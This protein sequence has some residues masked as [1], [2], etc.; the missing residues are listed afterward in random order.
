MSPESSSEH[1]LTEN[2]TAGGQQPTET[3]NSVEKFDG[4]ILYNP[5]GST[6]IIEDPAELGDNELPKQE[7]S[8]YDDAKEEPREEE[9]RSYPQIAN[10]HVVSRSTAYYNALYGQ[11]VVKLLQERNVPE[12]PVVHSYRVYSARKGS[13]PQAV[14]SQDSEQKPSLPSLV[15]VKPIL[16]CFICKLSFGCAKTFANHCLDVH[17]FSLSDEEQS[18]LDAK[19][20]S[21]ILQYVGKE[22][23]VTL[24][25]LEPFNSSSSTDNQSSSTNPMGPPTPAAAAGP[26][27]NLVSLMQNSS[28]KSGGSSSQPPLSPGAIASFLSVVA[29]AQQANKSSLP[30]V[31]NEDSKEDSAGQDANKSP[32]NNSFTRYSSPSPSSTSAFPAATLNNMT[33]TNANMLQG[34]TIGACPD[35]I[36]G[37]PTC[38]ECTKCDL[39]LSSSRM[40]GGTGWNVSRNSCKTL[41]CPKCNWHYKY[42]ETL[43]IHMKEKHPESETTCIYCITGQQH[44]RLARGETYTCGYKPYRCEVCNYSTTTKGNLSIHMQSDK[45]L[46]NMQELQNG[47]PASLSA[48]SPMASNDKISPGTSGRAGM[49]LPP[50]MSPSS[51][52][53]SPSPKPTWRC[54]VCNY[55]TN[56]ARNLRIHMTS[57]KHT[58]NMM[59]LSQQNAKMLQQMMQA[60]GAADPS[61]LLPPLPQPGGLLAP[62]TSSEAALADLAFNQAVLAQMMSAG[63]AGNVPN[64]P[65]TDLNLAALMAAA[66]NNPEVAALQNSES[67]EA[68]QEK[69][70]QEDPNPK[71]MFSC[72]VC[73]NFGC[74]SLDELSAHLNVDRSR[75]REHEVSLF[76]GGHYLCQLCNYKTNLKANFQLHCKTDKHLQR[77]SHVNHIKEGGPS[78][79]WKLRFLTSINPVE[80]RCN[81]TDFIT[82]S[83]HK[84][85]VHV[86]SQQFQAASVLFTHLQKMEV[87]I[88][89][90]EK[91]SYHCILCNFHS[92]TKSGLMAHVRTMKHLQMEQI[93]QLQKKAEGNLTLTEIGD[94]FQVVEAPQNE[95][96]N[97]DNSKEELCKSLHLKVNLASQALISIACIR[98][99][100]TIKKEEAKL[101]V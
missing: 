96:E 63:G 65:S 32:P 38:E 27:N 91:R 25:F 20:T 54:D 53:Q 97:S 35:H 74:D 73:R 77:L 40:A 61:K 85:Q 45:H 64:L 43:E 12:T 21:A 41:K 6:Y 70:N 98:H 80:L 51:K 50:T 18:I 59:A 100:R 92:P 62:P 81:A 36:N 16:M 31:P 67:P 82:N 88:E 2:S 33:A 30:K 84:L 11:A 48:A 99:F 29:A 23:E 22:Q 55:D 7:G 83:P 60:G 57:E 58:H 14:P 5:D 4:K 15:P 46:N 56:V 42:Q 37:R 89:E 101:H 26:L 66:Q 17:G 19:N 28:N 1:S 79:E 86:A 95:T 71:T 9:E 76:I 3:E 93:H 13:S 87:M 68:L 24:S 44:P 78:N 10:A 94:I 39:I 90:E 8:F 49:A 34:T 52:T 75:T 69:Q 72:L 47:G